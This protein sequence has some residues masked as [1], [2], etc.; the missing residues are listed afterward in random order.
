MTTLKYG[1]TFH[2]MGS[3][4]YLDEVGLVGSTNVVGANATTGDS[5]TWKIESVK[6]G[7]DGN[8]VKSGD[9]VKLK[10]KSSK[11][12]LCGT[13]QLGGAYEGYS[14]N[15]VRTEA[16]AG[17]SSDSKWEIS[18]AG[19]SGG[20]TF[21]EGD[22]IVLKSQSS[23]FYLCIA[24]YA[25]QYGFGAPAVYGVF[26][27]NEPLSATT[28]QWKL[29]G[30]SH[31]S[32]GDGDNNNNGNNNN[33][34]NNNG[35]GNNGNPVTTG[36]GT[37]SLTPNVNF[38]VTVL[39]NTEGPHEVTILDDTGDRITSLTGQKF[40][41][42]TGKDS[43]NN[44]VISSATYNTGSTGKIR[45]VVKSG[46]NVCTLKSTCGSVDGTLS[47]AVVGASDDAKNVFHDCIVFINYPIRA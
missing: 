17:D 7:Q 26:A 12:Y 35:N 44:G 28:T 43:I 15:F 31:S 24:F 38:G 1:D 46:G 36:A 3:N 13:T 25:N 40:D 16:D 29:D 6:S 32:G 10:N 22:T 4:T 2:L 8:K 5:A 19:G 9:I 34:N 37:L 42:P 20:D 11:K 39:T 21:A 47:Y 18:G 23:G 30:V 45:V 41:G 33:G 14:F 27:G